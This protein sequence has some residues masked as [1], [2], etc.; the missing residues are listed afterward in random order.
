MVNIKHSVN[1]G[2]VSLRQGKLKKATDF[3]SQA[4]SAAFLSKKLFVKFFTPP[5]PEKFYIVNHEYKFVYCPI[6]KV[7]STSLNC[8]MYLLDNTSEKD[9]ALTRF[10]LSG[11]SNR[12]KN[13]DQELH[14]L[15]RFVYANLTLESCSRKEA[16]KAINNDQYFKFTFVRD[17]WKR[18]SSAYLNKF[19]VI[20]SQDDLLPSAKTA[21]EG[22]YAA[23]GE[24]VD[25]DK[26]ITFR[27]FLTYINQTDSQYLDSHW[28]PQSDFIKNI[29]LDFIGKMES[30]NDDFNFVREKLGIPEKFS[31]PQ[32]NVTSYSEKNNAT[33]SLADYYPDE[34]RSLGYRPSYRSFYTPELI[35]LVYKRYKDD[36][37]NLGYKI[38]SIQADQE[39]HH[40]NQAGVGF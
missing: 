12:V 1:L 18:L 20:R 25:F 13:S 39:V 6:P 4:I 2:N 40:V 7:A 11:Q 10:A 14:A 19:A 29:N 5:W 26:S 36:F 24:T 22:F 37:E 35:D 16:Y 17:P 34:L 15:H 33:Q 32:K 27:Q 38:L 30:L 8:I 28:K 21:I 9:E 23:N 31:L 3:Y